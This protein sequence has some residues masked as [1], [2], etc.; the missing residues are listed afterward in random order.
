MP[1]VVFSS[2]LEGPLR[3]ALDSFYVF[4]GSWAQSRILSPAKISPGAHR[5][6]HPNNRHAC[7]CAHPRMASG[8]T[9]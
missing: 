3:R 4:Y 6:L 5:W 9:P 2:G 1:L 8:A 7:S